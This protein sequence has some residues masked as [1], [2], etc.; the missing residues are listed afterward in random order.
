MTI[1][2]NSGSNYYY[3]VNGNEYCLRKQFNDVSLTITVG[4]TYN[5]V[6]VVSI[7]N[8][9]AQL[10]LISATEV[11]SGDPTIFL[12]PTSL[13]ISDSGTNNT[14]T[15][16]ASNLVNNDNGNVGVSASSNEFGLGFSSSTNETATWGFLRDNTSRLMVRLP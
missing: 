1:T 7:Y 15:V 4:K 14:F 9:A 5:V 2:R 11:T 3:E 10:Y 16:E 13:T 12:S 8:D 6:G